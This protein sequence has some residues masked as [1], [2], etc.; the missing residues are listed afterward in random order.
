MKICLLGE[1]SDRLNEGYKNIALNLSKALSENHEVMRFNVKKM[2]SLG[3]WRQVKQ[4]KPQIAHYLTAPTVGSL[5]ILKILSMNWPRTKTVASSLHPYSL[6]ILRNSVLLKVVSMLKPDLILV[7]SAEIEETLKKIGFNTEFLP[8]GVDTERFTPVYRKTKEEL[9]EKYEIDK[10]KF[11]IL[12]VGHITRVRGLQILNTMQKQDKNNQVLIV[13]SSYFKKDND[14]YETLKNNGCT[15]WNSYFENIEEIYALADCYV[16]P[17]TKG[18]SIFMPLSVMEA[19]SCNLPV[20]STR[21]EGL[22][23]AFE[24]GEGL[25]FADKEEDFYSKLKEVKNGAIKVNTREKVLPYSWE[26]VTKRLE[27]I[28]GALLNEY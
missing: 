7:Q 28:Y 11:V 16:F 4:F 5:I 23:R 9:R 25:M 6:D 26:N 22:D 17:V 12:H 10:E 13:G 19:M 1:Y 8:N 18:N 21:F 14:L 3:F 2:Y 15:I 20:I 24:E 27:D